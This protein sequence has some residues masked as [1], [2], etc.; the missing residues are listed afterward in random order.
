MI[1]VEAALARDP[2]F[3]NVICSTFTQ[4][5]HGGQAAVWHRFLRANS[6]GG[7]RRNQQQA[8]KTPGRGPASTN[9]HRPWKWSE[10]KT[11]LRSGGPRKD[12]I[13]QQDAS[14]SL[15][16]PLFHRFSRSCYFKSPSRHHP[17][18]PPFPSLFLRVSV[19]EPLLKQQAQSE[20]SNIFGVRRI[21]SPKR[22]E[23]Y[24]P[25]CFQCCVSIFRSNQMQLHEH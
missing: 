20:T 14:A 15:F 1:Y 21:V 7:I 11:R 25:M 23:L 17:F 3:Y 18:H 24:I 10:A 4:A 2:S 6:A 5:C 13:T 19:C 12:V 9:N 16:P 22:D 8:A